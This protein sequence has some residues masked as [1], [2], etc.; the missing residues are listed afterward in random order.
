VPVLLTRVGRCGGGSSCAF[1]SVP[2]LPVDYA[3]PMQF[4]LCLVGARAIQ[5]DVAASAATGAARAA[6]S[7][8]A[9]A[10]AAAGGDGGAGGVRGRLLRA[11]NAL[12]LLV[13]ACYCFLSQPLGV[14]DIGAASPFASVR[15]HGGSNHLLAPTGLLQRWAGDDFAR[16]DLFGGGDVTGTALEPPARPSLGAHPVLTAL[17]VPGIVRVTSSDSAYINALYPANAT[18][19]LRP[20]IQQAPDSPTPRPHLARTLPAPRPHL[21]HIS[22]APRPRLARASPAPRPRLARTSAA[23]P[24]PRR[25]CDSAGTSPSSSTPPL[26]ARWAS[27]FA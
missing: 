1:S 11:G 20:G 4:G 8:P 16:S 24:P 25:C 6:K 7:P 17:L 13:A 21:A 19:E 26:G 5:L 18:S 14:M 23:S 12:L 22:P 27:S 9:S 15:L 10:G 3:I 2:A